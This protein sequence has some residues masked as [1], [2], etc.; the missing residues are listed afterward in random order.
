MQAKAEQRKKKASLA[1]MATSKMAREVSTAVLLLL[2][3]MATAGDSA[4]ASSGSNLGPRK[5]LTLQASADDCITP[6]NFCDFSDDQCC[7]GSV[8]TETIFG[9]AVGVCQYSS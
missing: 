4:A 3:L 7:S 8:C 9:K 2:L 5:P 6:E 1:A